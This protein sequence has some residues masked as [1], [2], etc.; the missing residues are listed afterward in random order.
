MT[1]GIL[2][3]KMI[4]I[5]S[6]NPDVVIIDLRSVE[7][8]AQGHIKNAVRMDMETYERDIK[9]YDTSTTLIF[10]CDRGVNSMIAARTANALGY[11]AKSVI[12]GYQSYLLQKKESS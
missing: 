3:A 7:E 1:F 12:G 10:C 11:N 4:D 2:N 9:K 5:Y 6:R 8:F